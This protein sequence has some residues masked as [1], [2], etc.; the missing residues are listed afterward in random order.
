MP[1]FFGFMMWSA[2]VLIPV[3]VLLTYLFIAPP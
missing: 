1:S 3:F 2:M